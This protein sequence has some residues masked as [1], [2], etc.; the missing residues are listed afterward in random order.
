MRRVRWLAL[1]LLAWSV[2]AQAAP[3][4]IPPGISQGIAQVRPDSAGLSES[5]L[6]ATQ[7]LLGRAASLLPP[8]WSSALPKPIELRW[9]DD[10]PADVHGRARGRHLWLDRE[11]LRNWM[12]RDPAASQD[13]PAV[14]AA[15]AA[16]LHELAHFYDLSAAGGLSRDPRLLDVAGW[17]ASPSRLGWRKQR[18]DMRDRSPDAYEL[19]SPREFV[20]VNLEYF[21]LDPS[22]ACRRPALHRYF[23]AHFDWSPPQAGCAPGVV[24]LQPSAAATEPALLQLDPARVYAVDYLLAE[25]NAQPMSRWGHSMLRLVICA[26]GRA[27]GPECRLDLQHHRVLS[28]RA[29]V[30]DV[31]ISSWRGLTGS[32]PSRLFVLPLEQVIDEY[33]KVELR[34]LTSVPLKLAPEE[35]ATLVERAAQLHWNYDGR[36]YFISNNCAVETF[37]LLH[38]GVP[39]LASQGLGSISPTGLMRRLARTGTAD[40]SML[41]DADLALRLGYRFESAAAYY[42]EMFALARQALKLPQANAQAWLA[43]SPVERAPWLEQG[44]LRASAALL[45]LEQ[46]AL[47]REEQLARGDLK[48]LLST[49]RAASDERGT[50]QAALAEF[51]QLG[52]S[53]SH[54][55][56]L[57]PGQ[58]YGLPQQAERDI[59]D[60]EATT[61]SARLRE[62]EQDLLAQGRQWLPESR[63]HAL[64]GTEANLDVLGAHLREL[65]RRQGGMR[66]R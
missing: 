21:L 52:G 32:Y 8:G 42:E 54:P 4:T 33:T 9:R 58:G 12:A 53:L 66:L 56:G 24:Y 61:Q 5:E 37:R 3:Q 45:L 57:A 38:D 39:R 23:T 50:M 22:Y 29:F 1:G 40:V 51:L 17:Q 55:A 46:A 6:A 25:P 15:L 11:L 63:R 49:D 2:A 34:S 19:S 64:Q 10:L 16:L 48:R 36:Y 13:D 60:R 62:Q 43:A 31:Q 65:H 35:I 41:D 14:R 59:L 20:A 26:P 7:E 18:N 44:D 47:R 28:F 30:D 27:P